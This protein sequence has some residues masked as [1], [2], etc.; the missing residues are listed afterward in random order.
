MPEGDTLVQRTPCTAEA[1]EGVACHK[2]CRRQA[3]YLDD[4]PV[5]H[6][7]QARAFCAEFGEPFCSN[8]RSAVMDWTVNVFL[9]YERCREVTSV[10]YN[11]E[12]LGANH[13][14]WTHVIPTRVWVTQLARTWMHLFRDGGMPPRTRKTWLWYVRKRTEF[15]YKTL[16]AWRPVEDGLPAASDKQR[17]VVVKALADMQYSLSA[18]TE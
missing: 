4:V 9:E 18:K 2:A 7:E 3:R 14:G 1:L 13:L 16:H 12:Y 5:A 15:V 10:A 17:R 6:I 11:A 8:D